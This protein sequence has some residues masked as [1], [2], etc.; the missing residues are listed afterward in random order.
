[1]RPTMTT[2]TTVLLR[3]FRP[4][5]NWLELSLNFGLTT[6]QTGPK[7]GS[8][9]RPPWSNE[10]PCRTLPSRHPASR[11]LSYPT[12][13]WAS[14]W[15]V[16]LSPFNGI[17]GRRRRSCCLRWSKR[18]NMV[19]SWIYAS[20]TE[21]S[22]FSRRQ[23]CRVAMWRTPCCR[24]VSMP[25]RI[26]LNCRPS[27]NLADGRRFLTRTS[28]GRGFRSPRKSTKRT[29]CWAWWKSECVD[30]EICKVSPNH[31]KNCLFLRRKRLPI[32][33]K[34]QNT[35]LLRKFTIDTIYRVNAVVNQWINWSKSMD[36][37]RQDCGCVQWL[38]LTSKLDF[39]CLT[40]LTVSW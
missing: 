29:R 24:K 18:R 21:P 20:R 38:F 27:M 14:F 5:W 23:R 10:P 39:S 35:S 1:M 33:S 37:I 9:R 36:F 30:E 4:P 8:W 32:F 19:Y 34:Y 3:L 16:R 17:T 40:F 15:P 28:V 13:I 7:T 2:Q 6:A 26:S 12:N 25:R 22:T 11:S 31:T